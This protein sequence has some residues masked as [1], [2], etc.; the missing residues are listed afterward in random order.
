MPEAQTSFDIMADSLRVPFECARISPILA[1]STRLEIFLSW[2]RS[3]SP[4]K[5][6]M[7]IHSLSLRLATV[8]P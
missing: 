3:L 5:T 4:R 1:F 2:N 8:S 7:P 6:V